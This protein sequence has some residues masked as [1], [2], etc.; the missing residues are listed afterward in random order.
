VC[1]LERGKWGNDVSVTILQKPIV[2]S[3]KAVARPVGRLLEEIA[4]TSMVLDGLVLSLS[5]A[6]PVG[7]LSLVQVQHHL[8]N[9]ASLLECAGDQ[10]QLARGIADA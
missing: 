8:R 3:V 7:N 4:A 10:L 6:D 2:V 5:R 1:R 9:A